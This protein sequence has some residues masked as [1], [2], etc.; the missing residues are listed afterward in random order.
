MQTTEQKQM[1]E[2]KL[3]AGAISLAVWNNTGQNSSGEATS[4]KTISIDRSYK[5]KKGDWQKTNS[6]RVSDLPK[7][8]L[9][10][11]KAYEHL[12]LNADQS[13]VAE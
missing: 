12:I 10:L 6:L 8:A 3:K 4:Y 11:S 9:I 13:Y 5:D 2:L 7:V 1:P